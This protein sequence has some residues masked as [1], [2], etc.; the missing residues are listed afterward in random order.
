MNYK[1]LLL[2]IQRQ[3]DIMLRLFKDFIKIYVDDIIIYSRILTEHIIYL[4][5]IFDLFRDKRINFTFIKFY[6][7]YS[8][9]ILLSQRIDLLNMFISIKKIVVIIAFRFLNSL[10]KIDYFLDFIEYLRLLIFKYVQ[11]VNLL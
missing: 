10:K 1:N 3:I 2:Y 8:S 6:L 5:K 7:K 9:M 11:R 4:I